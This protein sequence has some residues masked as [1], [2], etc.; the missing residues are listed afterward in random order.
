MG[1]HAWDLAAAAVGGVEGASATEER[2]DA[3][4][5]AMPKMVRDYFQGPGLSLQ[6]YFQFPEMKQIR[7]PVHEYFR[8]GT[9]TSAGG[10]WIEEGTMPLEEAEDGWVYLGAEHHELAKIAV[11]RSGDRRYCDYQW[12][13]LYVGPL[14]RTTS[15]LLFASAYAAKGTFRTVGTVLR[16][17]A[18]LVYTPLPYVPPMDVPLGERF[19]EESITIGKDTWWFRVWLPMDLQSL[20]DEHGG[21]P[22]F[23]LLHGFKECG[24][25]NWSQTKSGLASNLQAKMKFAKWFPGILVLPQL[26]R[27]PWDEQWWKHWREPAMQKMALACLEQ[28]ISKYGVDRRRVYCLGESLGTEGAWYLGAAKPG[29]FA[30]IGGSCGSVEPYDWQNWEWG[31]EHGGYRKLAEGIGRNTPMWFCHGEKD[32]FVPAEQSRR[33]LAALQEHRAISAVGAILGRAEA[34]EVVYKEYEDLDHH[35]WDKA[36]WDDGMIQWL[37]AQHHG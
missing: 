27:R 13:D 36:Y 29:L 24:W 33:L 7:N 11:G 14:L 20:K 5:L 12:G 18:S 16:G 17:V 8:L 3:Q 23:L 25:D 1:W 34:A 32:D 2:E 15:L 30:G 37:L 35:V 21:L 22:A 4:V 28:A 31:E 19:V 9:K 10:H 26:P 6:E